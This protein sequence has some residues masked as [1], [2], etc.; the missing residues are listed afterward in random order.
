MQTSRNGLTGKKER[1]SWS[2]SSISTEFIFLRLKSRSSSMKSRNRKQKTID[3]EKTSPAS[4]WPSFPRFTRAMPFSRGHV[5][6][7]RRRTLYTIHEINTVRRV[8]YLHIRPTSIQRVNV[9]RRNLLF[10]LAT[11]MC[12]STCE[13]HSLF[14][15]RLS[16]PVYLIF[17][18]SFSARESNLPPGQSSRILLLR[19]KEIE[20]PACSRYELWAKVRQREFTAVSTRQLSRVFVLCVH[21]SKRFYIYR[22][23]YR[24]HARNWPRLMLSRIART[25]AQS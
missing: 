5:Y 12:P 16:S 7:V 1:S 25:T 9:T 13:T 19:P 8:L 20:Y 24:E 21:R 3:N 15:N 18:M 2:V 17:K 22:L 14:R 11:I 23:M 4:T 6:H 10:I